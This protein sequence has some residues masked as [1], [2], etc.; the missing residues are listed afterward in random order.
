MQVLLGPRQVG[1]TTLVLQAIEVKSNREVFH[2]GIDPFSLQYKPTKT[3]LVGNRG[4]SLTD[5]FE[6]PLN[7]LIEF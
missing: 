5:F 2:S 4:M 6:L 7:H 1:K 3:I